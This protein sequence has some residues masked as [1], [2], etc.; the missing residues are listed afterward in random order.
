MKSF[1]TTRTKT[2]QKNRFI[3]LHVEVASRS[4]HAK[5][6]TP[7]NSSPRRLVIVEERQRRSHMLITEIHLRVEQTE[8]GSS[9]RHKSFT[10]LTTAAKDSSSRLVSSATTGG[11]HAL[12]RCI[13]SLPLSLSP[14]SGFLGIRG[15]GRVVASWGYLYPLPGTTKAFFF[16]KT[17]GR[18]LAARDLVLRGVDLTPQSSRSPRFPCPSLPPLSVTSKCLVG[19]AKTFSVPA[20]DK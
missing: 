6:Q 15:L 7:N 11:S 18:R 17:H 3:K 16:P 20:T 14:G 8:S 1:S 9:R 19:E 12:Q 5:D 13:A 10:D 4:S 2:T